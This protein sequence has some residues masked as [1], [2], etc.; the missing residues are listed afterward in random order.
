MH[1]P[2]PE[3]W[4]RELLR[5]LRE[6]ARSLGR[7][8]RFALV[9]ILTLGIGIG[10]ATAIVSVVDAILL[11]PLPFPDA[12]Q[13]VSIVQHEPPERPGAQE[14]IRGFTRHE[15]E[16]WRTSTRTLSALA[17]TTMS[18]AYARTSQGTARLWGGMVSGNTFALLGARA[19][20]GRTLLPGDDG[21]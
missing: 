9:A 4:P 11:R 10:A 8:P 7:S 6:A 21:R 14:R 5:E 15:L 13:L 19:L 1:R 3:P 18:I 2:G 16:Q 12:G 20:A 17:G